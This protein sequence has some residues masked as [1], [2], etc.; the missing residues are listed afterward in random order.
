MTRYQQS[1]LLAFSF[2]LILVVTWNGIFPSMGISPDAQPNSDLISL[3]PHFD[4]RDAG[5]NAPIRDQN[6]CNAGYAFAG[7]AALEASLWME[8]QQYLNLSE[9]H[10]KECN[11]KELNHFDGGTSCNGGTMRDLVNLF[12]QSG[13]VL[14]GCD[15]YRNYDDSCHTSCG[16]VARIDSWLQL[17]GLQAANTA[18]IKQYLYDYGPV[19]TQINT[20]VFVNFDTYTGNTVLYSATPVTTTNHAVLIIGWD[21]SRTHSGG[22]G[23]WIVRNSYGSTW[24]NAGYG[25]IAYESGK[26]GSYASVITSSQQHDPNS[27]IYYYDEAGHTTQYATND[28]PTTNGFVLAKFTPT[29]DEEARQIEFATYD[30]AEVDLVIYDAFINGSPKEALTSINDIEVPSAGYHHITLE[31]PLQL[32]VGDSIWVQI[33]IHNQTIVFP[34][35]V[36]HLGDA[37]PLTSWISADS[38]NWTPLSNYSTD[39]TIRLLTSLPPVPTAPENLSVTSFA[40]RWVELAWSYS[41]TITRTFYVERSQDGANWILLANLAASQTT[42]RD[43]SPTPN[44]TYQYRVRAVNPGGVSPPSN[45]ISVTTLPDPP[46]APQQLVGTAY[47]PIRIQLTWTDTSTTETGFTIQESTNGINWFTITTQPAN[48]QTFRVEGLSAGLTY[49]YRL[50]AFNSGGL[51]ATIYSNWIVTPEWSWHTF[52]PV[53]KHQIQE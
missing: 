26:I 13:A 15:P 43:T 35:A 45:I 47:S 53:I 37:A 17:S 12:S 33:H 28:P 18:L 23:A 32:S 6:D 24:G 46:T 3:P 8:N 49:Q 48:T 36:D 50:W 38:H 4:W 40:Q 44:Q 22:S 19:Y 7:T 21:D 41:G 42:F 16:R 10:A 30:Q 51:S 29:R 11:W 34:V 20:N 52:L 27:Q 9:N 14:E 31:T 5:Y 2:F 39:S 25:Y 1:S